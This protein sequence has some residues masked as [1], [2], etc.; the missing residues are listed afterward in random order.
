[1]TARHILLATLITCCPNIISAAEISG[2]VCLDAKDEDCNGLTVGSGCRESGIALVRITCTVERREQPKLMASG[3][4]DEQGRFTCR[5]LEAGKATVTVEADSMQP[6][7]QS[8]QIEIGRDNYEIRFCLSD[9]SQEEPK[10]KD[11]PSPILSVQSALRTIEGIS[12]SNMSKGQQR[13]RIHELWA[14]LDPSQRDDFIRETQKST[15]NPALLSSR[16]TIRMTVNSEEPL[17]HIYIVLRRLGGGA[18]DELRGTTDANGTLQVDNVAPG[19][20]EVD[21]RDLGTSQSFS[22]N[23][24]VAGALR[25]ERE[26]QRIPQGNQRP[27]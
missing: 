24:P 12:A 25:I 3:R 9:G 21:V 7:Q 14:A 1:M 22:V 5:D 26:L 17:A 23:V 27:N 18:G 10:I 19:T 2:L 4:T 15:I 13:F 20:W 6:K 8:R 16:V 11:K